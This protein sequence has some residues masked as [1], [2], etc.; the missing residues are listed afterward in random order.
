LRFASEGKNERDKKA[1][2]SAEIHRDYN[3]EEHMATLFYTIELRSGHK[4][5]AANLSNGMQSFGWRCPRQN[6]AYQIPVTRRLTQRLA[7]TGNSR[8]FII[9]LFS[10]GRFSSIISI[11]QPYLKKHRNP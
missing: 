7:L 10:L 5:G 4:G 8:A 2:P 9:K 1:T 6:F 11:L 3:L